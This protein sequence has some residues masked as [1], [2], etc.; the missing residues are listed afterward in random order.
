MVQPPGF[1]DHSKPDYFC[2]LNKAIYGL[3][4]ASQAWHSAHKKIIVHLGFVYS[5]AD[6]SLFIFKNDHVLCYLLVYVDDLVV[7][8][9]NKNCMSQIIA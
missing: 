5:K 3:K 2:K 7:T 4:Q 1:K 9:N 8:G 6:S